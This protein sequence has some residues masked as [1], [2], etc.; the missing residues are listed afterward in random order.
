MTST[1]A[2]PTPFALEPRAYLDRIHFADGATGAALEPSLG[3]LGSLHESHMLAVP[4]ENLSIHYGQPIVLEEV[5][6]FDKIVRRRRGGFCYELNGLFAWLLRSLGFEVSLLSA[7][8][9]RGDGSYN[10]DF[11]HLTL[12]VHDLEGEDWL[13]D[14][15][16]G[17][18]F[19]RPLRLLPD[20]EQDGADLHRY[21][22][23]QEDASRNA[24]DDEVACASYWIVQRYADGQWKP[25]Y[26]FTLQPRTLSDF[27][28]RCVYQQTSPDSHF[29]RQRICTLALPRGRVSLSDLRLTTTIE[30]RRE[31][32]VLE[33]EEEYRDVLA[34]RFG[35]VV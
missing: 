31:E 12:R 7:G 10:P 8:V 4:F 22:L 2:T 34:R 16:F 28:E 35:I 32:R 5:A 23:R 3:L 18:S 27:T 19:R 1:R 15:G 29:T 13:A 24:S 17:S 11:D 6:L 9:A 33:S 20:V 21:R 26:R 14:V 30:G 25:Q